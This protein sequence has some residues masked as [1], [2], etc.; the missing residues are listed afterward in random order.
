MQ[1]RKSWTILSL[2][3]ISSVKIF[4]Q[5]DYI[6]LNNKQY[7]LLDR[8]D[9][10]LR[11]DSVLGFTTFKPYNRKSVTKRVLEL[12]SLD[13]AGA[14]AVPLS[15]IDRYNMQRLL[16]NNAEWAENYY[17]SFKLKKPV[18]KT[19]Y[20]TPAALF[21]V[22]T[23][24]F[25]LMVNPLLN[26]QYGNANDGTGS[27]FTN[28]RG[29]V[30]RGNIDDRIGFWTTIADNQERDPAYV[31]DFEKKFSALPGVGYYKYYN[32]NGYDYLNA[33]GGITFNAGKYFDFVF[34]YDKPFIGDGYRSLFLSD[35]SSNYLF[36]RIKTRV[37]KLEYENLF[38]QLI[39]AYPRGTDQVLPVK[40]MTLHHLSFQAFKWL[41]FGLYENIMFG[42]SN[43]YELSY[44]NPVIFLRSAEQQ[45]GSPDKASIGFNFKVNAPRNVQF[46]G[47]LLINEFVAKEVVNYKDGDWRNKQAL[48]LGAKYIDALGVK[49]LDLQGEVNFIRPY[50]YTHYD[51]VGSF[52]NYNQPLAHPL[53][54]NARELVFLAKYQPIPK[55]YLQGKLIT[56]LQGLDSAGLNFG[57]NIFLD[58][59]T[60][61]RDKGFF[62]GTGTPVYSTTATLNASYEIFENM[63]ID[64]NGTY[65]TYNVKDMP[66]S[67]VFFYSFGFRVNMA[68]REFNF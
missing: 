54:A 25:K 1:V 50:V 35:F 26:L 11:N 56:Y 38:T 37:W 60:R 5:S 68:R 65:R 46:Y 49:N 16:M 14:L 52:S 27:I 36:L 55:L 15:E 21:A 64:F 43:G 23:K 12:D 29:L 22:N 59:N 8:L 62:I 57:S 53:G 61:P 2:I 44:L 7:Q 42:R 66:K 4:A 51:S 6:D 39:S 31:R 67:N 41:N 28:T 63:F 3:I 13:K 30:I 47:Q 32:T 20:K 10:K 58:Y 24:D 17:D 40:Y 45:A 33:T 9:I 18:L 19:F 48:Q 34:G